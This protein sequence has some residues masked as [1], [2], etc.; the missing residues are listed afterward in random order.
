MANLF[1]VP[2][3]KYGFISLEGAQFG[4]LE[5]MNEEADGVLSFDSVFQSGIF[6]IG[7]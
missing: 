6:S 5:F 4:D 3:L 7:L 2:I 1:L